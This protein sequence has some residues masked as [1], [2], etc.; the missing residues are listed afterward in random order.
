MSDK[1]AINKGVIEKF[2]KYVTAQVTYAS[3]MCELGDKTSAQSAYT[4]LKA[5][6]DE[7]STE[8]AR[9]YGASAPRP[10]KGKDARQEAY[11]HAK[12]RVELAEEGLKKIEQKFKKV[13]WV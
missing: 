3:E 8:V 12:K 11:V 7:W 5:K 4:N 1:P 13:G 6:M 2:N 10:Y 9:N